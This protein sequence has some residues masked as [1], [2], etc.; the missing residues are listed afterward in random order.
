MARM[1]PPAPIRPQNRQ[2]RW[3]EAKPHWLNWITGSAAFSQ[4]ARPAIVFAYNDED[5]CFVISQ[6]R[7]SGGPLR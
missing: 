4:R 2:P 6:G 7:N 1:D 3:S 5:D